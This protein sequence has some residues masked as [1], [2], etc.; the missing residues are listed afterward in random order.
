[1]LGSPTN[2][3]P[4]WF[5]L[6]PAATQ[7]WI[8]INVIKKMWLS[9]F[10][11][12]SP[13]GKLNIRFWAVNFA[14]AK[15]IWGQNQNRSKEILE[16][17]VNAWFH[18]FPRLFDSRVNNK[19]RTILKRSKRRFDHAQRNGRSWVPALLILV[20]SRKGRLIK[21]ALKGNYS[22]K[23]EQHGFGDC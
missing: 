11:K 7:D 17:S 21:S 2:Q 20:L 12:K 5:D 13:K 1:M 18:S 8:I 9:P 15:E 4:V 22:K 10:C 6:L 3:L 19:Q 23:E 14:P 16:A